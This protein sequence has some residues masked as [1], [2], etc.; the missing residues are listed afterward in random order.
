LVTRP[1]LPRNQ[2]VAVRFNADGGETPP[3]R[4]RAVRRRSVCRGR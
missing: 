1:A 2:S 3:L 4:E